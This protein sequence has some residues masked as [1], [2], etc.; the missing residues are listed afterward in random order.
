MNGTTKAI[1]GN[2]L[3][4]MPMIPGTPVPGGGSLQG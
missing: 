1:I 4:V 2:F 3:D